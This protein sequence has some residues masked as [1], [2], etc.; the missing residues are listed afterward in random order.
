MQAFSEFRDMPSSFWAMVKFV[1]Q[2]LG[3]TKRG[4]VRTYTEEEIANLLQSY[5]LR[6]DRRQIRNIVEY[7]Q[8]RADTLNDFVR[9]NLMNAQ[10]ARAEF[11]RLYPIHRDNDFVCR[12]TKNKQKGDMRQI[13]YFTAMINILAECVIREAG[14]FNGVKCFNDDPRSLMYV[15]DDEQ[16]VGASSR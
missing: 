13:A 8:L 2:E 11:E 12:L 5:G 6:T 10:M 7:S 15:I 14:L 16:V 9:N 1:S 4:V 3:Y